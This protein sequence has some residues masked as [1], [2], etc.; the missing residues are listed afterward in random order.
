MRGGALTR[1][2]A[3]RPRCS[4]LLLLHL[5]L[6]RPVPHALLRTSPA[7]A[8]TGGSQQDMSTPLPRQLTLQL[9]GAADT[10][11]LGAELAM[12]AQPGDALLLHGDYG[13]GK[14]C[15]ARGFIR[16][17]YDDP[18]EQVTSPSYLI[19]NVY[20]DADGTA[21]HPGV[22]VHH[23]DLWRLPEGKIEQLVD[24]PHVFSECVSLIEWPQRLGEG[25]TPATH[26]DVHIAIANEVA[27]A[28]DAVAP[29]PTQ[30]DEGESEGE[31]TTLEGKEDWYDLGDD[32]G[33]D[34][35][36]GESDDEQPRIV[37]LTAKGG[38]WEQRLN[39]LQLAW[40]ERTES[41]DDL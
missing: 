32:E 28:T 40:R 1:A 9:H 25:L 27:Q 30:R 21:L 16:C 5:P 2:V 12:L 22:T 39:E 10:L 35:D 36:A 26:L 38:T 6:P 20:D 8:C 33:D 17:W 41:G 13:A 15:L 7:R 24:L 19:D 11:E 3:S 18:A 23:M 4:A 29:S 37:T 34:A 14:T 31:A